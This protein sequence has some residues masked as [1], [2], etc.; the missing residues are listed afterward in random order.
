MIKR[1]LS[2]SGTRTA[3]GDWRQRSNY[4]KNVWNK[5]T[6]GPTKKKV[7]LREGIKENTNV[8][9]GIGEETFDPEAAEAEQFWIKRVGRLRHQ[10]AQERFRFQTE[11]WS[12]FA[13]SVSEA[14]SL[15]QP[16]HLYGGGTLGGKDDLLSQQAS[17]MERVV[18]SSELEEID[19]VSR[20]TYP[21]RSVKKSVPETTA[22][23]ENASDVDQFHPKLSPMYDLKR[24]HIVDS[25][26]ET[27]RLTRDNDPEDLRLMPAV[28]KILKETMPPDQKLRLQLWEQRMV[29]NMGRQAFEEMNR[30]TLLRGERLHHLLDRHFQGEDVKD[31]DVKDETSRNHLKSIEPV[32]DLFKRPPVAI[33]SSVHHPKLNYRG[34]C[35]CVTAFGASGSS[36]LCLIDWKTS[37]KPKRTLGSTFD[38]PIQVAAYVGALNHDP[39]YSVT[40]TKGLIVV[41]YNDGSPATLLPIETKKLYKYWWVWLQKLRLHSQ[42][43]NFNQ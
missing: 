32:L 10:H 30:I 38:N 37:A 15:P 2:L 17:M 13:Q 20:K 23:K 28:T 34:Y 5:E 7:K 33:E 1:F 14:G 25:V 42:V 4:Y 18:E 8:S 36:E 11:S 12:G 41:V 22:A 21:V 16:D 43:K 24:K 19:V 26:S 29:A 39:R 27:I 3:N 40:V 31:M 9:P 6:Y 35:D